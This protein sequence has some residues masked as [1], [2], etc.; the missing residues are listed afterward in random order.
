MAVV[1]GLQAKNT[2]IA[3]DSATPGTLLATLHA[4]GL[5]RG[6]TLRGIDFR[7]ATGQLY[8]VGSTDRLYTIDVTTGAATA[9]GGS[10]FA[11]PLDKDVPLGMDFN[12]QTDR[13]RVVTESNQDLRINPNDGTVVDADDNAPS[14]QT[15]GA[16]AYDAGDTNAGQD[17]GVIAVA[18]TNND[19][20]GGTPT[21]L[22]GMD[23]ARDVL[24]RQGSANA[25]PISPNTG[26]LFTVGPLNLDAHNLGGF[27]VL[28]TTGGDTALAAL[29]PVPAGR[30]IRPRQAVQSQ[31]YTVSTSSGAVTPVGNIGRSRRPTLDIAAAPE[32]ITFYLV[33]SR[34]ELL[35]MNTSTPNFVLARTRLSGMSSKREHVVGIDVRPSTGELWALSDAA[36]L[37]TI[38]AAS[39]AM[40]AVGPAS[41]VSLDN[42]AAYGFDFNPTVDLIR[43]NNSA[44]QNLR[45]NPANG[46]AVDFDTNTSGIDPDTGL[47][48]VP[49]DP[50]A[51]N[52]D[53]HVVAAA[54]S[55]SPTGGTPT[56]LYVIDSQR[57]VLAT[58]G[59]VGAS[60]TIPNTG[61]L[62]TIG[63]TG[64]NVPDQVGFDIVTKNGADTALA[65]F[66]PGN[67]GATGIYNVNLATGAMSLVNNLSRKVSRVVGF[68]IK[69]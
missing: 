62:F 65:I 15:D 42:R 66:A 68:A 8:G 13:I 28:T 54:H 47:A 33:N 25:N 48:Y 3:F 19:T 24:V 44:G 45:L 67:H 36:Q 43:V 29:V 11:V 12:P 38:N 18:Y 14:V 37:Y 50:S 32:G 52:R 17:P 40:T 1:F 39:G 60:P 34:S 9:V 31:L 61:Q 10:T 46:Q 6:E 22:F 41:V 59:S 4:R 27:D 21:T 20:D 26:T 56:T 51:D 35:T 58:Q 5:Q 69:V 2:L 30:P 64:V 63:A 16:L 57:D 49:G 53:P 7:P 23:A 55:N